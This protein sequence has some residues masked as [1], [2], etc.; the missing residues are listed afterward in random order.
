MARMS[1]TLG[2]NLEDIEIVENL[3]IGEE[4]KEIVLGEDE[5]FDLDEVTAD[6]PIVIFVNKK[7]ILLVTEDTQGVSVISI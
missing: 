1:G 5:I 2:L 3:F 7:N 4:G 6:I